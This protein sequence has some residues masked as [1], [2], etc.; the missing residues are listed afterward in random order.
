LTTTFTVQGLQP[1]QIE[2][3]KAQQLTITVYLNEAMSGQA[4]KPLLLSATYQY[5]K[6]N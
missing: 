2:G 3:R 5:G 4:A 1:K 6:A